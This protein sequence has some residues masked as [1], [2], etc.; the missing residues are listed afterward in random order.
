MAAQRMEGDGQDASSAGGPERAEGSGALP[1]EGW[2]L[3]TPQEGP[4]AVP[5]YE[6]AARVVE[7]YTGAAGNQGVDQIR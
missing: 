3:G 7:D 2:G 6:G 4:S 5:G 1:G